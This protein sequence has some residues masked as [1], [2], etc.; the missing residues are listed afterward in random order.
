MT[1]SK[2]PKGFAISDGSRERG[3]GGGGSGRRREGTRAVR[4]SS[5]AVPGGSRVSRA[6]GRHSAK[7]GYGQGVVSSAVGVLL[8]LYCCRRTGV[9]H[10]CSTR[11]LGLLWTAAVDALLLLYCCCIAVDV[12][13]LGYVSIQSVLA[14]IIDSIR[15]SFAVLPLVK[16]FPCVYGKLCVFVCLCLCRGVVVLCVFHV[17]FFFLSFAFVCLYLSVCMCVC[18]CAWCLRSNVDVRVRLRVSAS[19]CL[20]VCLRVHLCSIYIPYVCAYVEGMWY[21]RVYMICLRVFVF[22][23]LPCPCVCGVLHRRV[24]CSAVVDPPPPPP[25]APSPFATG[26][27]IRVGT[28]SPETCSRT[29]TSSST[30]SS[31]SC[32][33]R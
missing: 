9:Y 22:C 12:L 5:P 23:M 32:T 18:V 7:E 8:L 31:T 14:F 19:A 16:A 29:P 33:R 26:V 30:T 13:L 24:P 1:K 6:D 27:S 11:P 4:R 3:N 17:F 21:V 28:A 25:T 20:R 10:C 2:R 15:C